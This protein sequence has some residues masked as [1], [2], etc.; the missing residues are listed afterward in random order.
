MGSS[1]SAVSSDTSFSGN[2][3]FVA[4]QQHFG[5]YQ[6]LA[7]LGRGGTASVSLAVARGQGDVRKLV[8][9]KALLPELAEEPEA[10]RSFIEEAKVAAQLNHPNVVQT[11]EVG[12]ESGR[13]VIVMEYLDGQSL[14]RIIRTSARNGAPLPLEVHLRVLTEVLEGLHYAHEMKTFEGRPMQLVHRDVSPQNVIVTY[15]GQVK[16]LDFGIAKAATSSTHTAAGIMKGKIAYMAPEQ[17]AGTLVDRRA[18]VYSAGC[19]LWAAVTNQKLWQDVPDVQ[20]VRAV[21][22]GKIPSPRSVCPECPP[23]LDAIVMRALQPDPDRRYPTAQAMQSELEE[24]A[25]SL[26]KPVKTRDLGKYVSNLFAD[27]RAEFDENVE[28]EL[29]LLLARDGSRRSRPSF[30]ELLN[31]SKGEIASS[32]VEIPSKSGVAVSKPKTTGILL[33]SAAVLALIALALVLGTRSTV[34]PQEVANQQ[35]STTEHPSAE[36]VSPPP[37]SA[38]A[39]A[40]ALGEVPIK[41]EI[42]PSNAELTLDGRRL[43]SGLT[44]L[45]LPVNNVKHTLVVEAKGFATQTH[46]FEVKAPVT[47]VLDLVET[48]DAKAPKSPARIRQMVRPAAATPAPAAPAAPAPQAAQ[49]KAPAAPAAC[50]NPF[51]VDAEGIKR[52]RPGCR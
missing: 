37:A 11:F 6:V 43:D 13:H 10:V 31:G 50:D 42:S 48:R 19:M 46:A 52:V 33:G 26:G 29:S 24:F 45:K 36:A 1:I 49:P 22:A 23:E 16:L 17:M 47:I 15:D 8:V 4:E 35:R 51:Y 5:K 7:E 12:S 34:K 14:S 18:D 28:R 9:L 27:S 40:D 39:P 30:S 41:L 21:I 25:E 32:G 20:V 44:E 3:K 38:M 2:A